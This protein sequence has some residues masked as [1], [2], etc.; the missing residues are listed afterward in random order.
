MT[1]AGQDRPIQTLLHAKGVVLRVYAHV[2]TP[3]IQNPPSFLRYLAVQVV[4]VV[5]VVH[6]HTVADGGRNNFEGYN[7]K[8]VYGASAALKAA[9]HGPVAG[10]AGDAGDMSI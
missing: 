2:H 4:V 9:V 7:T 1:T 8:R 3:Y 10:A 6:R 5:V